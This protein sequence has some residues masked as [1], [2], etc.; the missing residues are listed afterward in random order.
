MLELRN[1]SKTVAGADHIRDVSLTLRHGSLNVLLGL[2]KSQADLGRTFGPDLYEAEVRY[3]IDH[4]WALTAD[5]VLWRRT[6]RGL[7]VS[8]EE[9]AALEEYMKGHLSSLQ[10]AAAE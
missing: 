5:D 10:N 2:A 9:A 4:E 6:K 1:V 7:T 3:L 8:A